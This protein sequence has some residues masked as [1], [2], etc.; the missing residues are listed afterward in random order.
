MTGYDDLAVGHR[1]VRVPG[2]LDPARRGL[3]PR[4]VGE[5]HQ[6]RE[7]SFKGFTERYAVK[8]L[9][10]FEAFDDM[11]SAIAREKQL[12]KWERAWKTRS[13]E[14]S[15]LDWSDLAV[16]LGFPPLPST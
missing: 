8:R 10:Y 4:L 16:G 1:D 7:G 6:H 14:E 9:V 15:N 3:R 11:T 12:T 2:Q 13:I 5:V